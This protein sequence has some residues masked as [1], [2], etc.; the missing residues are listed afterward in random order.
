MH[1]LGPSHSTRDEWG[2]ATGYYSR[3]TVIPSPE[4]QRPIEG[5]PPLPNRPNLVHSYLSPKRIFRTECLDMGHLD[6][7]FEL[8][9]Y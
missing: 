4:M 3:L 9:E 8:S 7:C 1:R 6:T 2:Q 5:F